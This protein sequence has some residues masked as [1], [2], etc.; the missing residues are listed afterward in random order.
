MFSDHVKKKP[1][2]LSYKTKEYLA[3]RTVWSS[4]GTC[5]VKKGVL[6]N[7]SN[8]TW[9]DPC[10]SLFLTKL[11]AFTLATLL[12]RDSNTGVFLWILLNV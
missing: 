1:R 4:H 12:M 11:Q 9:K 6:K 8:F 2:L 10:W 5:S 7:F 3:K